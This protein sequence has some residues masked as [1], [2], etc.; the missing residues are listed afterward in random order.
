MGV[1]ITAA[2]CSLFAHL[3]GSDRAI[4]DTLEALGAFA[5]PNGFSIRH[6]DGRHRTIGGAQTTG[7]AGVRDKEFVGIFHAHLHQ[8]TDDAAE[9]FGWVFLGYHSLIW[10]IF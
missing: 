10:G 1:V 7:D 5:F 2:F 9:D 6:G 4:M 8:F 3:N